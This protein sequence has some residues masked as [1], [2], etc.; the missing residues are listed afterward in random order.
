MFGPAPKVGWAARYYRQLSRHAACFAL[1]SDMALLTLGGALKRKETLSARLGDIFSELYLLSA[2]LK[3][4][5]D[6]GRQQADRAL[7][8]WVMASGLRTIGMRFQEVLANFPNRFVAAFLRFIV[9][10]LGPRQHGPSDAHSQYCAEVLLEPSAARDRLTGDLFLGRGEDAL[11]RLERAFMLTTSTEP[12]AKKMRHAHVHDWRKAQE[13]GLI[14][15]Q[16]ATQMEA[17]QTAVAKVV[18]VDDFAAAKL[19][20][21]SPW[22][23]DAGGQDNP[24]KQTAS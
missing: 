24:A 9:Q 6:E 20:A 13:S 22:R 17:V 14:D 23:P 11:A 2:A 8:A 7:L 21:L 5:E 15:A 18:E 3:R 4:F 10:P 12:I 19:T 16:E 1:V